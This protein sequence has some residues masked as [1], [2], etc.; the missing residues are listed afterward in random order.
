MKAVVGDEAL[1][2]EDRLYLT[3]LENF[4][5]KFVSQ[6]PYDVRD[7]FKSLDLAWDLLRVFPPQMLKKIKD[8]NIAKY[9]SPEAISE[10]KQ[11][12]KNDVHEHHPDKS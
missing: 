12:L 11:D 1:N 4:E 7:I 3:F 9:Y 8:E 6:G 2:A 5:R 10:A